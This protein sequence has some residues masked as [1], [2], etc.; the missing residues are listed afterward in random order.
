MKELLSIV[1]VVWV[2]TQLS[3]TKNI[4]AKVV[5]VTNNESIAYTP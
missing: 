3:Y 1:V 5:D 4:E 2:A